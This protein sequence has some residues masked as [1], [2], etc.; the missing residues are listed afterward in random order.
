VGGD[1]YDWYETPDG[2]HLTF[3]DAMGKGMGA[4]LI[5]ATVRAVMRSVRYEPDLS[6]AFEAASRS[7]ASDLDLSGS[8][9]TLFHA[10]L[11]SGSGNVSYID[12]GHGLALHVTANGTAQRLPPSGPPVGAWAD[13]EWP[14][15]DLTLAPGDSLVVV[16]DGVLDAF[17]TVEDFTEAVRHA[18]SQHSGADEACAALMRLAPAGSAQDDVT[19]VVIRRNAAS[20]TIRS[21]A[22]PTDI[23][24]S[25]LA[26]PP[27][28]PSPHE[29]NSRSCLVIEDDQDIR[30]LLSAILTGM[31][32]NVYAEA[33]G[34]A[35][36]RAAET[37]DL[38]LIT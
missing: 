26:P 12:A 22:D 25:P 15:A 21:T 7:I 38:D 28:R 30:D 4:A 18:T 9:T 16:S 37:L 31:G 11:D 3:A 8:F 2:L 29:M 1:F 6:S 27:R 35:G 20:H 36:L 23:E 13:A 5:A 24:A 14:I 34:T 10:R 32:F 17:S 19:S 33:T